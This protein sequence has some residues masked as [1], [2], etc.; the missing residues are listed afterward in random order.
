MTNLLVT[1]QV[2]LDETFN[3][4]VANLSL[5]STWTIT[6]TLTTGTGAAIVTPPLTYSNSGKF[7]IH[8]GLGK[9]INLNTTSATNYIVNKSFTGT[10]SVSVTSG[11]YYLSFL[12][13]PGVSQTQSQVTVMGFADGTSSGPQMWVG[14]GISDIAK[15]RF[16][17]NRGS[18]TGSTEA[19]WGTTEY[20]D[21]NE[22]FLIVIKW[23]FATATASL[24]VN[25]IVGSTVEPTPDVT[26]NFT[27]TLRTQLSHIR[28]RLNGTSMVNFLVSGARVSQSWNEAVEAQVATGISGPIQLNGKDKGNFRVYPN[29]ASG[30]VN[31]NYLL[32]SNGIVKL[33]IYN[34]NNQIVKSFVNNEPHFA[35][36]YSRSLDVSGLAPGIYFARLTM[37][38]TSKTQKLVVNR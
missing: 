7:Y 29:P 17:V 8:S 19:I 34:L 22:V 15:F 25:P 20:A 37:G 2:L 24:F 11:I 3:Y 32:T 1:S 18:Q 12:F 38:T 21:I 10:P 27:A 6:N 35:G 26:D 33:D 9:T 13:K 30:N 28:F 36:N 5:E 4:P 23:D 14:K 16:A 31:I